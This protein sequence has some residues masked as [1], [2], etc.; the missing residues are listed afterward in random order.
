[1]T[2]YGARLIN[3]KYKRRKIASGCGIVLLPLLLLIRT[4][5]NNCLIYIKGMHIRR[6]PGGNRPFRG[7]KGQKTDYF[8]PPS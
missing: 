8:R 6:T 3:H 4:G 5:R 1:M 2:K 7:D